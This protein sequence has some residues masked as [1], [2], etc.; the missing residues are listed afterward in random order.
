[1]AFPLHRSRNDLETGAPCS[2]RFVVPPVKGQPLPPRIGERGVCVFP[3]FA[4][5]P[6]VRKH[7]GGGALVV[8]CHQRGACPGGGEGEEVA[9]PPFGGTA[10]TRWTWTATRT[11]SGTASRSPQGAPF[12]WRI[13]PRSMITLFGPFLQ[14][15]VESAV[16]G[17]QRFGSPPPV[18][19]SIHTPICLVSLFLF[20]FPPK[21]RIISEI[22]PKRPRCESHPPARDLMISRPSTF[23]PHV[24]PIV[25]LIRL[26]EWI[27][28]ISASNKFPTKTPPKSNSSL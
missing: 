23:V 2:F 16:G 17:W 13:D 8:T 4:Q 12:V 22:R 18:L 21:L 28:S 20:F 27:R 24:V 10:A 11:A 7:L 1:M 15:F 26:G 5:A 19:F 9:S 3:T 25:H 6:P 14:R